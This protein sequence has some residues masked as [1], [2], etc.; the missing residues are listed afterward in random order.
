M[1][2][3]DRP[4]ALSF[5]RGSWLFSR[6][7]FSGEKRNLAIYI[8]PNDDGV[9]I[10]CTHK[11]PAFWIEGA[12]KAELQLEVEGLRNLINERLGEY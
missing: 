9:A 7:I 3:E 2:R 5:T 1:V 10:H 11:M 8:M 6:A 4:K 12:D